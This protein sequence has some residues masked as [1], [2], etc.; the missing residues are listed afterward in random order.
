ME[1]N[2]IAPKVEL[3]DFLGN[4]GSLGETR[5]AT[6]AA[7][8]MQVADLMTIEHVVEDKA[9]VENFT[10]VKF[11]HIQADVLHY[12]EQLQDAKDR[13]IEGVEVPVLA[14]DNR[15]I[16]TLMAV[17]RQDPLTEARSQI[18]LQL[19]ALDDDVTEVNQLPNEELS[20]V[21]VIDTKDD[22][23]GHETMHTAKQALVSLGRSALNQLIAFPA[24]KLKS[25]A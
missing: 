8:R 3:C 4:P 12:L 2:R 20:F 16:D 21:S 25:A 23:I 5:R 19:L 24:V 10:E 13:G 6:E 7:I 9:V 1:T 11:E 15:L 17:A 22:I 14:V 18:Q